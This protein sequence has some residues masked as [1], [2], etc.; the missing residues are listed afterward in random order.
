MF[1]RFKSEEC[2]AWL[3][4]NPVDFELLQS[5]VSENSNTVQQVI[6]KYSENYEKTANNANDRID[7]R[8]YLSIAQNKHKYFS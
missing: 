6:K 1:I 4:D 8:I 3:E 5:I 2:I 7:F